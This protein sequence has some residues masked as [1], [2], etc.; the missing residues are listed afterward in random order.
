[1]P[2]DLLRLAEQARTISRWS[3]WRG[4]ILAT[5]VQSGAAPVPATPVK[6]HNQR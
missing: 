3:P 1:L 5:V 2:A 6:T 4:L